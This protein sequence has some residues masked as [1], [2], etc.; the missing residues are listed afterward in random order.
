MDAFFSRKGSAIAYDK[1]NNP[2]FF[3]E[4]EWILK[5]AREN[6]PSLTFHET[7]DFKISMDKKL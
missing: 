7:S 4:S 6:F 2:V 1:E 3:A 5:T